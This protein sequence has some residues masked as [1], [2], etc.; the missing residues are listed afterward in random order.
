M[1]SIEARCGY[2]LLCG[3]VLV[4]ADDVQEELVDARVGGEL[5]VKGSGED[6][7][8]AD[9]DREAVAGGEGLYSRT[10]SADARGADEDHLQRR[11]GE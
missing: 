6:V 3:D 5:R 4:F 10:N 9:E 2:A 1:A 7:A 8:V 11:A